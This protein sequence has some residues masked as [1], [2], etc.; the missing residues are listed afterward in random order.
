MTGYYAKYGSE[1][2]SKTG[3]SWS[4]E[5][6]TFKDIFINLKCLRYLCLCKTGLEKTL[7]L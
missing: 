3:S 7:A 5:E 2:H 1:N 4:Y 6:H